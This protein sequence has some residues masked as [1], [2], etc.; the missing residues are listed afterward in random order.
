MP[1]DCDYFILCH[2]STRKYI[3][4]FQNHNKQYFIYLII[5]HTHKHI[6]NKN[7]TINKSHLCQYNGMIRLEII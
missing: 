1:I 6:F 4:F 2:K 3:Y 7:Y 5:S